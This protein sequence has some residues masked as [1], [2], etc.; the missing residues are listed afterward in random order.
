MYIKKIIIK[1]TLQQQQQQQKRYLSRPG[2]GDPAT[3][4]RTQG[5]E[6]VGVSIWVFLRVGAGD[7]H[8]FALHEDS[9][10][11]PPSHPCSTP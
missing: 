10:P 7:T 8:V 5:W 4:L 2:K 3:T 11:V 9:V 6:H 1:K